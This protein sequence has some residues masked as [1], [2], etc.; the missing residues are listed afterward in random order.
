[1]LGIS[2]TACYGEG[3]SLSIKMHKTEL[4][5]KRAFWK[6]NYGSQ[7]SQ[8]EDQG[9]SLSLWNESRVNSV[10][11]EAASRTLS[12]FVAKGVLFPGDTLYL[13]TFIHEPGHPP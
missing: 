8:H 4:P 9:V 12:I 2:Q 5:R 1:M 10:K 13:R 11:N 3:S 6:E 7:E